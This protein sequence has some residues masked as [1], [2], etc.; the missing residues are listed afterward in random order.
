V[1]STWELPVEEIVS[2][3]TDR[4]IVYEGAEDK[5]KQLGTGL[6]EKLGIG[7]PSWEQE[8][9][10]RYRGAMV[11]VENQLAAGVPSVQEQ[12]R[13]QPAT[14]RAFEPEESY[15]YVEVEERRQREPLRQ[16]RYLED[17]EPDRG[18]V[19]REQ[20]PPEPRFPQPVDNLRRRPPAPASREPLDVDAEDLDDP[21]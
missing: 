14:A 1:L 4:I 2:S 3:G 19:R 5:L 13:I 12:R 7:G 17:D 9:R 11:P 8:E 6:L 16:R 18:P 21:W 10:E 15:D 20:T